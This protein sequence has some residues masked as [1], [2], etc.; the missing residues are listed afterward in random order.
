LDYA[1]Q[2]SSYYENGGK[3]KKKVIILSAV[4]PG[5]VH[6]VVDKTYNGSGLVP[7]HQSHMTFGFFFSFFFR[8]ASELKRAIQNQ[9]M[10]NTVPK[11]DV[12]NAFPISVPYDPNVHALELVVQDKSQAL[13]LFVLF[14]WG[15][16][17]KTANWPRRRR[18]R[19]PWIIFF[20]WT[21]KFLFWLLNTLLI[22]WDLVQKKLKPLVSCLCLPLLPTYLEQFQFLLIFFGEDFSRTSGSSEARSDLL[23]RSKL[24]SS[25]DWIFLACRCI[26]LYKDIQ[27]LLLVSWATIISF[28]QNLFCFC[29]YF[30]FFFFFFFFIFFF[31]FFF[32]VP[33]FLSFFLF[34]SFFSFLFLSNFFPLL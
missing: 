8:L 21:L 2:Y 14:F 33:F 22:S 29:L 6:P 32:F 11:R 1:L 23:L 13:P 24:K 28:W 10:K 26:P 12:F 17:G 18:R 30:F 34:F 15:C 7:G 4:V 27:S 16:Y 31:F 3:S 9:K 20:F 19:R 25:F 5:Q